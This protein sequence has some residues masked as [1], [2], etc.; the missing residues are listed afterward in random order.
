MNGKADRLPEGFDK[1]ARDP[2]TVAELEE[3]F[4]TVDVNAR[5]GYSEEPAISMRAVDL[6]GATWLLDHG[7]S[8]GAEPFPP[9]AAGR[10]GR[11]P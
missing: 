5:G 7:R 10:A 1:R 9:G 2:Y 11:S 6:A 3:I 8:R 4:S